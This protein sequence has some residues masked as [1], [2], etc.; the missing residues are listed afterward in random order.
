MKDTWLYRRGDI[1]LVD[2]GKNFGSEQ[3]VADLFFLYRIMWETTT[4]PR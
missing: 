1:Y 2:L 3:G 4:V